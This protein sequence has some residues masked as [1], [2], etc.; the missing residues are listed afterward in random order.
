MRNVFL[1]C[2]FTRK[3]AG[4]FR[5]LRKT[6]LTEGANSRI[7]IIFPS[8]DRLVRRHPVRVA[9]SCVRS[10]NSVWF[11]W[12]SNISQLAS[13]VGGGGRERESWAIA[14]HIIT[15]PGSGRE[16]GRAR[17]GELGNRSS[18]YYTT[19]LR[20]RGRERPPPA[21]L[22][23]GVAFLSLTLYRDRCRSRCLGIASM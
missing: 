4:N 5:W 17:E 2:I 1:L 11:D 13:R 10:C 6:S 19:W 8:P 18:Y 15:L 9:E 22:P 16:A 12:M 20:E 7:A 21:S 14:L 23:R 3:I